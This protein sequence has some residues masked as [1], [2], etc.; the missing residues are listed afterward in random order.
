MQ[1]NHHSRMIAS[2]Y[3]CLLSIIL[4][5]VAYVNARPGRAQ[6]LFQ[7]VKLEFIGN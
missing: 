5:Y 2:T 4:S 7:V 1:L 3:F 6:V